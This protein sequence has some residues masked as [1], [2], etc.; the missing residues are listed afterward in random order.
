MHRFIVVAVLMIGCSQDPVAKPSSAQGS[1]VPTQSPATEIKSTVTTNIAPVEPIIVADIKAFLEERQIDQARW[2]SK[3]L[4]KPLK[5]KM[6]YQGKNAKWPKGSEPDLHFSFEQA[7]TT[8]SS[9]R[10]AYDAGNKVMHENM[11][12]LR[13][14]LACNKKVDE[15]LLFFNQGLI[16]EAKFTELKSPFIYGECLNVSA[17]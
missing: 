3:Y 1:A 4:N 13:I 17:P 9:A 10:D 2:E 11:F 7:K 8:I 6:Y 16:V 14:E 5:M 15:K 12:K